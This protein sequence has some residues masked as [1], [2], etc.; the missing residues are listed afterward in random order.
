MTRT[1]AFQLEILETY[2]L[3]I[4]IFFIKEQVFF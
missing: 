1:P 2:T 4:L 3:G